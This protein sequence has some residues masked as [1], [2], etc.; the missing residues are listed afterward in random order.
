MSDDIS[1]RSRWQLLKTLHPLFYLAESLPAAEAVDQGHF[2]ALEDGDRSSL[3]DV[4]LNL[5]AV[6]ELNIARQGHIG[7][8]ELLRD[9]L[10][11]DWLV[12]SLQTMLQ[13]MEGLIDKE[14]L[15][16]P[17][18][19]INMQ[20]EHLRCFPKLQS[21]RD[22]LQEH[23][24][25]QA[26]NNLSEEDTY[27]TSSVTNRGASGVRT[28]SGWSRRYSPGSVEVLSNYIRFPAAYEELETLR[29]SFSHFQTAIEHM[30]G[31]LHTNWKA[32]VETEAEDFNF[33]PQEV[34]AIQHAQGFASTC[35]SLF[36]QMADNTK[37]GNPHRAKLHLS[38]FKRDQLKMDIGTCQETDWIS[39]VFT[40]SS[41]QPLP[42]IFHSH[43][44]CSHTS[45]NG[46]SAD[47]LHVA[48]NSEGMWITNAEE[49]LESPSISGSEQSLEYHLT[50]K[51]GLT[52]KHRK[53]V[54]VL[55]A[56]SI[57]Q[58]SDNPWV[59]QHLDPENIFLPSPNNKY[60][61]RWCPRI[62]YTLVSSQ[63]TRLQSDNIVALGVLVMELEAD[64][65]AEWIP[66]DDDWDSGERSNRARLARMLR[67]WEDEISDDYRRIAKAC[68]KFDD[69]VEKLKH[70][71]IAEERKGLAIIYKC[72]LEPLSQCVNLSFEGLSPLIKGMFG[73]GRSLVSPISIPLAVAR[74]VILFDDDDSLSSKS[75]RL[76]SERFLTDLGPFF[77]FIKSLR[78]PNPLHS[79]PEHEKIRIAGRINNPKSKSFV[80][81]RDSWRHDSYGHGSQ[82]AQLLLRTAP[83][84]EVYVG[85]ICTGK[86][87]NTEYMPGIADAINW[88]T[89]ECDAH[90]ISISFAF[91][92]DD[93]RIEGAVEK[94]IHSGKQTPT[95]HLAPNFTTPPFP[96]GPLH[97][98][99][100]V[101]DLAGYYP[102]NQGLNNRVPIP[103]GQCY[104]DK[105]RDVFVSLRE[106]LGGE[107]SI[108]AKVL[109]RSI[110]GDASLKG[111]R[112]NDDVYKIATLETINFFPKPSYYEKCLQLQDVKDFH[113]MTDHKDPMYL[114]TGLKIAYGA[115]ISTERGRQME[116][117]VE[118]G[119]Q[120][121]T[122][123][124]D[125]QVGV[126]AGVSSNSEV[127]SSFSEPADFVLGIQ[128]Q[129]IYHKRAFLIGAPKLATKR[130]VK[131]AVLVDNDEP[132][133]EEEEEDEVNFEVVNLDD[134]DMHGLTIE[135]CDDE[136]EAWVLPSQVLPLET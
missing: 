4:I 93:D 83:A 120:N 126:Q 106:S 5:R 17:G 59:A 7:V 25:P 61:Q 8:D 88:A 94:A 47:V 134:G 3:K 34:E 98:G 122:G 55:L 40:R 38:G 82:V 110:G 116:G 13:D 118:A 113:Q 63:D 127:V 87:V 29:I 96:K 114:I 31:A 101:E 68:L 76:S 119:V 51:S 136:D 109:D 84:A 26:N 99:T 32:Q 49:E 53:L 100:L 97:L 132:E 117:N 45:S 43:Q 27:D 78:P 66:E 80:G 95:Y 10:D 69:L 105:K 115:T 79:Q 104:S 70:P 21:L 111:Q 12:V 91:E 48:F 20:P 22:V 57:F 135:K 128:V 64:C 14:I 125:L 107:G 75:N 18:A 58:L 50:H 42:Q 52:L 28:G 124:V 71:D 72:I 19:Q 112:H 121:A 11:R 85:K 15:Q 81:R 37:C 86:V 56:V 74:K 65:K 129:K 41:D 60:L 89:N 39:A 54:S 130:V 77:D 92:E 133:I 24:L 44:I 131:N 35:T 67:T 90:I 6:L 73:P 30:F 1:T 9:D 108:L 62:H 123:P 33:T 103:D 23:E 46:E 102:I 2:G 16:L 36:T